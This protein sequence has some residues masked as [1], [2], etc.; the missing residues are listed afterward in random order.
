M[1]DNTVIILKRNDLELR[2]LRN[3]S[4]MAKI[5]VLNIFVKY[6]SLIVLQKCHKEEIA[7]KNFLSF[8][9]L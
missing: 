1:W 4:G 5:F 9:S 2:Q 3:L 6:K 7:F 8:N